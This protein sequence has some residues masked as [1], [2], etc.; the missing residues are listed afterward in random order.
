MIYIENRK[1]RRETISALYPDSVIADVTSKASDSLIKLSPFY[2][3]GNIPIPFS[4]NHSSMS[5]EG[6]WQGLKV[7]ENYDVDEISFQNNK[8]KDIKRTVRKYGKPLGHRKGI[9]GTELLNYIEARIL[10]YLPSYLWVLENKVNY[11]INRLKEVNETKKIVLLDYATNGNIFDDRR[12]LSHAYLLKTYIEGKYPNQ[13]ELIEIYRN[14][15][16]SFIDTRN[17]EVENKYSNVELKRNFN[18][19]IDIILDFIKDKP[20][21]SKDIIENLGLEL[22]SRQLT[23]ILK[24][25]NTIKILRESPLKFTTQ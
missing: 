20:K 21:S 15:E 24:K 17:Y 7:F 25:T 8:M 14:N 9:G 5:V 11:I 10:I 16:K 3:H 1:K 13:K 4:E 12:P 23:S 19:P 22:S 6:I 18:I 2:P